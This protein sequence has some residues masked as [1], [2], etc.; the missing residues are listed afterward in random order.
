MLQHLAGGGRIP[1][2]ER[3][4]QAEF[5]PVDAELAGQLVMMASCAIAPCGTPNPRNAPEGWQCVKN[6]R[7]RVRTFG[8]AYG[9]VAWMGTRVATVGPQLA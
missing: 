8:T 4:A 9:P 2:F 1:G 7:P 6:P 5:E 3:I